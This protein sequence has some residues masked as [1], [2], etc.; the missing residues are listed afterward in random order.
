[1]QFIGKLLRKT[2]NLDEFYKAYDV[3]VNND[4]QA[5]LMFQ[6]LENIRN[7][8]LDPLKMN[9]T[10]DK[11]IQEFPDLDIQKL[12]QLIRNH[13]KEVEKNTT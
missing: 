13:H 8:L 11:L 3:L 4:K 2:D 9:Y 5:N 1:T 10:L 6:H 12:M 7:N